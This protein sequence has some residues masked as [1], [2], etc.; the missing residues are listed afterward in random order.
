MK[1]D[2]K[3]GD[4]VDLVNRIY[5]YFYREKHPI[6]AFFRRIKMGIKRIKWQLFLRYFLLLYVWQ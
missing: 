1:T 2:K 3:T 5:D 6:K 4:L